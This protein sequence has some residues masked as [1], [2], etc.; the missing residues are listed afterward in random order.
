MWATF[1]TLCP[2]SIRPYPQ[3]V[4]NT[5]RLKECTVFRN[6]LLAVGYLQ[7][8]RFF[9]FF[10]YCLHCCSRIFHQRNSTAGLNKDL[11]ID[12]ESVHV[13]YSLGSVIAYSV[14]RFGC[15]LDREIPDSGKRLFSSPKFPDRLRVP[16]SLFYSRGAR[17]SFPRDKSTRL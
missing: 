15:G 7:E 6:R 8:L 4:A 2:P 10:L 3:L 14:Y 13:R 5:R 12:V 11:N 17:G 9:R 16:P 1:R